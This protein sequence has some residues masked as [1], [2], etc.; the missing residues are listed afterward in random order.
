MQLSVVYSHH[1]TP[2]WVKMEKQAIPSFMIDFLLW[3]PLKERS[4][5]KVPT[6]SHSFALWDRL[7]FNTLLISKFTPLAH[8]FHNPDFP[9]GM[10]IRAFKWWTDKGLY[11]NGVLFYLS[12]PL[13]SQS[14]TKLDMPPSERFCFY[15][16]AQRMKGP[17]DFQGNHPLW[18][19][20]NNGI[21]KIR[22][23]EVVSPWCTNRCSLLFKNSCIYWLGRETVTVTWSRSLGITDFR[24]I[25]GAY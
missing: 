19:L 6:L 20:I 8:I 13:L 9:P 24:P 11:H 2:G 25:T 16:M 5:I 7:R 1:E 15:Q 22:A 18:Q 3:G 23:S 21:L 12:R 10:D 14:S 17:I 4:L